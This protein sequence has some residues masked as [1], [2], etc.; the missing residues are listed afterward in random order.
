MFY[1]FI[2]CS[3]I[4]LSSIYCSICLFSI[5]LSVVLYYGSV[6][7]CLCE[8]SGSSRWLWFYYDEG[9][10]GKQNVCV[11]QWKRDRGEGWKHSVCVV[12]VVGVWGVDQLLSQGTV[13]MMKLWTSDCGR[14]EGERGSPDCVCWG[15]SAGFLWLF[16][17][18][19]LIWSIRRVSI[20]TGARA[21]GRG[22]V[23]PTPSNPE[24]RHTFSSLC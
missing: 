11:W 23:G 24:Q 10:V 17:S 15:S 7:S 18:L 5:I 19:R 6:V 9:C 21:G 3:N 22:V 20:L 12:V 4:V 14:L 2:C 8:F 1:L 13:L 16:L